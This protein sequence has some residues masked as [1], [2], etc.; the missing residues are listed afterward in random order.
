MARNNHNL[1]QGRNAAAHHSRASC[2][3]C[4]RTRNSGG[5]WGARE[6]SRCHFQ[7]KADRRTLSSPLRWTSRIAT[8]IEKTFRVWPDLRWEEPLP[9][10]SSTSVS[11]RLYLR[12]ATTRTVLRAQFGLLLGGLRKAKRAELVDYIVSVWSS[13]RYGNCAVY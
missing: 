10:S 13:L 11:S 12:R 8:E 6:V 4:L 2:E 3:A 9:T 1:S 5:T 7:W